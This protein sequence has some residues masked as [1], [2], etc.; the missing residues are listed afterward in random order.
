MITL[1]DIQPN[2][3]RPTPIEVDRWQWRREVPDIPEQTSGYESI[4]PVPAD[5]HQSDRIE[6]DNIRV[7]ANWNRCKDLSRKA[8]NWQVSV[9]NLA[10]GCESGLDPR[11]GGTAAEP[12]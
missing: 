10:D 4:P 6:L 7:E 8:G 2:G 3:S 1:I 11:T 9:G 5:M 12:T